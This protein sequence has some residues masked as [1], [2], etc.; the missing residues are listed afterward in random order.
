MLQNVTIFMFRFRTLDKLSLILGNTV[1]CFVST[2]HLTGN[3]HHHCDFRDSSSNRARHI[4]LLKT[5]NYLLQSEENGEPKHTLNACMRAC[6][7]VH[8][9]L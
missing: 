9:V 1:L 2:S 7:C 8:V 3:K 5:I 6:V 4:H